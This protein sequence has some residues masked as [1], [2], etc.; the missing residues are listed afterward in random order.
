MFL[1]LQTSDELSRDELM[2][3][4]EVRA[5]GFFSIGKRDTDEI[6]RNFLLG[7][8]DHFLHNIDSVTDKLCIVY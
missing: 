5:A 7:A 2:G 6:S 8:R 4:S 3:V 1:L